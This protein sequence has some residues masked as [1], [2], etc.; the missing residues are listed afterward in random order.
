[1][2]APL[3]SYRPKYYV[4]FV[5]VRVESGKARSKNCCQHANNTRELTMAKPFFFGVFSS[6]VE[7][8]TARSNAWWLN[9]GC[10]VL[11]CLKKLQVAEYPEFSSRSVASAS[12]FL[13]NY[14]LHDRKLIYTKYNDSFL[15]SSPQNDQRMPSCSNFRKRA[16]PRNLRQH[17]FKGGS[18]FLPPA[19]GR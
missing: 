9:F 4:V 5:V 18:L 11:M 10:V 12:P 2:Y 8:M 19:A 14:K 13:I 15:L 3:P 16:V 17:R 7:A 1:M 6:H